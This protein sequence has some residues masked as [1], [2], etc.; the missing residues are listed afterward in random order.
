MSPTAKQI[1][2]CRRCGGGSFIW[3][4]TV[5]EQVGEPHHGEAKPFSLTYAPGKPSWVLFSLVG[6]SVVPHC[7]ERALV[8]ANV[9][10]TCALT[11]LFTRG[12]DRI[13]IGHLCRERADQAA[14]S[15]TRGTRGPRRSRDLRRSV[16]FSDLPQTSLGEGRPALPRTS[17]LC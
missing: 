7:T 13:P 17:L 10:R 8:E 3:I 1:S 16:A 12:F 9:C 2:P 4:P 5:L 15:V 14:V 11:E 6:T